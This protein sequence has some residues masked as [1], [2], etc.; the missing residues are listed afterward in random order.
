MINDNLLR[1]YARLAVCSGVNVQKGQLLVINAEVRDHHFAEMCAEEAY[2]AGAGEVMIEWSDENISKMSYDYV[3]TEVLSEVPQWAYDKREYVQQKGCCFL[4]INSRTPGLLKDADPEKIRAVQIA[5]MT[6]M[7]P[8]REYTMNNHGQWC[9]VALPS[10]GWAKRIF[11]DLP[12]DEAMDRLTEAILKSVRISEDNDPVAEW[13]KHNATL[14]NHSRMLNEFNFDKLHFVNSIGTDL[15]VGL[16][17]NH[18]WAG[19]SCLT[20]KGIEFNPNMPTEEVFCMP[21][22]SRVD[23]RVEASKP[24]SYGG[25]VI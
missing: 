17:K 13:K 25:R 2:K 3:A 12:D 22:R 24:L 21:D 18:N 10:L 9:I 23:G 14:A 16:V 5:S 4:H 1:K 7:K 6:K 19:G 20:T 11:P 15:Y 8:L